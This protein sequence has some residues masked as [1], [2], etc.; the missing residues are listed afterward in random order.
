[1]KSSFHAKWPS[2][3]AWSHQ[4]FHWVP[5][6]MGLA[7]RWIQ[8]SSPNWQWGQPCSGNTT[9]HSPLSG[10]HWQETGKWTEAVSGELQTGSERFCTGRVPVHWNRLSW[11]WLWHQT[12][13]GSRS[14]WDMLLSIWFSFRLSCK[15]WGGGLD[16]PWV[17]SNLRYAMI[18]SVTPT[19]ITSLSLPGK[20]VFG[21]LHQKCLLSQHP[22]IK[23]IL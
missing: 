2:R 12:C 23:L 14:I 3:K 17:P 16:D 6:L 18:D 11:K 22:V 15:Q 10:D 8:L 13:Q 5:E 4:C 19:P 7:H 1:M 20:K 21:C 9:H